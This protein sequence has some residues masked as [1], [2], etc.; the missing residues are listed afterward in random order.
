MASDSENL[1]LWFTIDVDSDVDP[2]IYTGSVSLGGTITG[3]PFTQL[4]P[5]SLKVHKFALPDT[6]TFRTSHGGGHFATHYDGG[7][8]VYEFHGVTS[9]NDKA[10][11]VRAYYD[12]MCN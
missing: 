8:N 1:A 2:G 6:V 11:L 4:V 7:H 12:E 9:S 10:T 3:S 5:V